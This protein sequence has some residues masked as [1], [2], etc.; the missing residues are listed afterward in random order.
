[1]FSWLDENNNQMSQPG[2][3]A[4]YFHNRDYANHYFDISISYPDCSLHQESFTEC[5]QTVYMIGHNVSPSHIRFVFS[6][7][8]IYNIYNVPGCTAC[9][10]YAQNG[11][12]LI[13]EFSN[14][15]VKIPLKSIRQGDIDSTSESIKYQIQPVICTGP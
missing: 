2:G 8:I 13:L 10:Q 6:D 1:M 11:R 12:L 9:Q 15:Y 7:S 3:T 4:I 14:K 5:N